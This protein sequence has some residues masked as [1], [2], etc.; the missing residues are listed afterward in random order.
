MK[1]EKI[2]DTEEKDRHSEMVK[3][4]LEE[5]LDE[6]GSD[7]RGVKHR[8]L[9]IRE[10]F[11]TILKYRKIYYKVITATAIIAIIIT[12][13]IPNYYTCKVMLA[14]E[15]TGGAKNNS[16]LLSLA[17]NF[18][19]NL[20]GSSGS[21]DA[22]M[23]TLYPDLI[24]SVTFRASLFPIKVQNLVDD[25]TRVEMTYYDYLE[26]EQHYPWWT[27][28]A[29]SIIKFV[30]SFLSKEKNTDVLDP[31]YLTK[32]QYSIIEEMENKVVCDVD[33]KTQVITINVTD[34]DAYI[35]ATM[36]DS[37]QQ[38]LQAFITD[39]RT[40]KSRVDLEHYS[41]LYKEAKAD[42]DRAMNKHALFAD[43]NQKAFLQKIRSQESKLENEVSL[44]YQAYSQVVA[45]LKLAEAKV[46]E[47]TPAFT[48]LQPATVPIK[49]AGPQRLLLI[50]AFLFLAFIGTSAVV[51]W[52]NR[53]VLFP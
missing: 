13:S 50:F 43:A 24:N 49:K 2:N 15:I 25:S 31:F 35:A 45:Q 53:S 4:L 6:D 41:R 28:G 16:S 8:S 32:D 29:K 27:T 26:N 11:Y 12:L 14:P 42:Y 9:P 23:P 22:L 48:M 33:P 19:I 40:R 47:D 21:F 46:Q 34:Q 17:S 52:Q 30:K 3:M 7:F 5:L 10:M 38:R 44:Q 37:V 20:N 39:Y 1:T 36:A 51:F 18:G